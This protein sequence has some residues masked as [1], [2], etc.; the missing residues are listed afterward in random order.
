MEKRLANS[1]RNSAD[2]PGELSLQIT[3]LEAYD[4]RNLVLGYCLVCL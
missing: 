4:Q 2:S 1:D 3:L